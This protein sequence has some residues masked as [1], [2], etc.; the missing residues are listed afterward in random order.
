LLYL[1]GIP[2]G[3]SELLGFLFLPVAP[4]VGATIGFNWD[5]ADGPED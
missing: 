2:E 3:T 1:L 4:A 5:I